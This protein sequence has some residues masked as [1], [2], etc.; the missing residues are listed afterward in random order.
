MTTITTKTIAELETIVANEREKFATFVAARDD[1][2]LID[3]TDDGAQTFEA[4]AK[5]CDRQGLLIERAETLLAEAKERDASGERAALEARL[6][7][8]KA[9]AM[10]DVSDFCQ[11]I[12]ES[13]FADFIRVEREITNPML[14]LINEARA[15]SI[16]GQLIG[17]QLNPIDD[18]EGHERDAERARAALRVS[19]PVVTIE[20]MQVAVRERIAALMRE[21]APGLH[22]LGWPA[23]LWL[24]HAGRAYPGSAE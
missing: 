22:S 13:V 11:K 19:L 16:E 12:A 18:S 20:S 2:Q 9:L 4:C 6:A 10:P 1:A 7:D 8:C 17:E 23:W 5:A 14:C 15:A 24:V 3:P 21:K